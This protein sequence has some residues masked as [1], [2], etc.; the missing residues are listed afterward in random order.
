M[1]EIEIASVGNHAH[2]WK[3]NALKNLTEIDFAKDNNCEHH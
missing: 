3:K 2:H 1:S